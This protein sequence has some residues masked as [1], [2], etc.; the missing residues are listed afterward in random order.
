MKLCPVC[1]RCYEDAETAC[2]NDQTALVASRQG[3]R[4]IAEKYR[5]DRLLGRGGMGAVYA[6]T[7][8]DLDRP[9]AIKLLLS[10]FTADADALERFR[11]EARAAARLNH[12]N[13]AD[14]YDY[15]VL[16]GGGAYIVMEM[17]EGQTLREYMDA[18]GALTISEAAEIGEQ[19]AS[20]IDAAHRSG[21]IHR[22]LKPSNII[23]TRDHQE[24]LQAKV[25]DF[26]VAKLK[27]Y[28]TT[29]GGLTSSGSLIGTP[30]YMSPEQCSGHHTDARSDIYS[31]GVILYEMLAGRPPFDAPTATAIAIKHI[32]QPPPS[33]KEAR[34]DVPAKL[35]QL[36]QQVLNKD[37][38]KRPPTAADFARM[39][40]EAAGTQL[41]DETL[42]TG[43]R[44]H[45]ESTPKPVG[46][47][48]DRETKAFVSTDKITNRAGG[49]T[50]EH[51]S[52]VSGAVDDPSV[53]G[54]VAPVEMATELVTKVSEPTPAQNQ[55]AAEKILE[56][57]DTS[58]AL[59]EPRLVKEDHGQGA[60]KSLLVIAVS[61]FALGFVG[62]AL[63]LAL[64]RSSGD[65]SGNA[66]LSSNK[67]E[68]GRPTPAP[69]VKAN[70]AVP[71]PTQGRG[72]EPP[73]DVPRD[74]RSEL[75]AALNAW[76]NATNS[77]DLDKQISFY[78]PTLEIFYLKRNATLASVRAEKGRLLAQAGSVDVRAGEPEIQLG[79]DNQT[80]TMRFRK[81]WN[82]GGARPESGEVIQEL[83]WRKINSDWKIV[84]ERDVEVIRVER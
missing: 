26:G 58:A 41:L 73:A 68:S 80:A 54:Y 84:G 55:K 25:V 4:M 1:H 14:T 10:D 37:P 21:I 40:D 36:L 67:T 83:R 62:V 77:R 44:E 71:A 65:A 7:H 81:S 51:L 47:I 66:S 30:R 56:E 19:V 11:R 23:L 76:V 82:F 43:E 5:L 20:G 70:D 57:P 2:L 38:E 32:Q 75:R 72:S 64:S 3:T 48:T 45:P 52:S 33:L 60:R 31:M 49:P 18:A 53:Q 8:V 42:I 15:G 61:I 69:S 6:G 12:P 74:A 50:L 9:V 27:E 34:A 22:D 39:L 78:A 79:P 28:S 13:I 16:Q 24:K 17:I 59:V 46:P 29:G 35:D 63:W